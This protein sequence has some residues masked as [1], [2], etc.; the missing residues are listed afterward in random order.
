MPL[1][2]RH[3]YTKLDWQMLC[4]AIAKKATRQDFI[5]KI[6]NWINTTPTNYPLTDWYDAITGNYPGFDFI[7][8][9]VVG[10]LYSLLALNS[11]P[12]TPALG[13]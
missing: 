12:A 3:T 7:A 13:G 2:T 10:S 9:P 11:A 6:V 8:R 1:D 5:N 4:A